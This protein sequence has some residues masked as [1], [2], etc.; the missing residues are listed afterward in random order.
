MATVG[1]PATYYTCTSLTKIQYILSLKKDKCTPKIPSI[2]NPG[3]D[4]DPQNGVN[5][6]AGL[7]YV[8]I[9]FNQ[10]NVVALLANEKMETD[11]RRLNCGRVF[12]HQ[13]V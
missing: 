8:G 11:G 2:L 12:L 6:P 7:K 10:I 4:F 3:K 13:A 1:L 9:T 5:T